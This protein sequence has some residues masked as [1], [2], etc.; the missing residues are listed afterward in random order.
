MLSNPA[1]CS[2]MSKEISHPLI[3][4]DIDSMFEVELISPSAL[5]SKMEQRLKKLPW[6]C[7][8]IGLRRVEHAL[9]SDD[10]ARTALSY[11]EGS[12]GEPSIIWPD[13]QG[14]VA[15][16]CALDLSKRGGDIAFDEKA[17]QWWNKKG[18]EWWRQRIEQKLVKPNEPFP[19]NC[20]GSALNS[21]TRKLGL[22][23]FS[24]EEYQRFQ[25]LGQAFD[26]DHAVW[27]KSSPKQ[28]RRALVGGRVSQNEIKCREQFAYTLNPRISA[29]Y[30][31]RIKWAD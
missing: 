29:R 7:P 3:K 11:L 9:E 4:W 13:E 6:S 24:W 27:L 28:S 1:L 5:V 22:E 19:F 2:V 26:L 8:T 23:L 16:D 15:A 25:N 20:L 18:S 12:C 14:F 10:Q 17:Y 30:L 31:R 21:S